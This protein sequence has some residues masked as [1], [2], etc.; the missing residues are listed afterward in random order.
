MELANSQSECMAH[1]YRSKGHLHSFKVNKLLMC[2]Q[3]QLES[4]EFTWS[5]SHLQIS[6]PAIR[7]SFFINEFTRSQNS[8][9]RICS[10]SFKDV[11]ES[12]A[13]TET[14]LN[15][16]TFICTII[17]LVC[18]FLTFLIYCI[19]P[20]LRT[21]PGKN[22][23]CFSFSLFF[24]QLTV[25]IRSHIKD[26]IVCAF[27]GGLTHYFW[28]SVFICTNIC[29]FQM[30]KLF[31]SYSLV[32]NDKSKERNAVIRYCSISYGL[33]I[34]PIV[35]NKILEHFLTNGDEFG[36]GGSRCFLLSPLA[37]LLTFIIPTTI[38]IIFNIVMFSVTFHYIR[39]T[40][41]VQSSQHRNEFSIFLK[42][43]LLTGISWI[44]MIVDGFFEISPFTFLATVVNGSQGLFLFISY[45][46]NK[47]VRCALKKKLF[48][49]PL[50]EASSSMST[51]LHPDCKKSSVYSNITDT[52]ETL[53]STKM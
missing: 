15:V 8:T 44:L 23:M 37:L 11:S 45:I 18:L 41:K 42:L 3:I 36:Y 31:V 14:I 34:L 5:E 6:I 2:P 25:L 46:C 22:I 50:K 16:T 40:P 27:L 33:P 49:S 13:L 7:R 20:V 52:T 10:D 12:S 19:L 9:V 38:Q 4:N 1:K 26:R 29:C 51:F 39:N 32:Q 35:L 21:L 43:F 17:S 28:V 24:A 30:F 48:K 47:K 53:Q